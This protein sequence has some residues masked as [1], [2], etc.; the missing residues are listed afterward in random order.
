MTRWALVLAWALAGL[1]AGGC[2]AQPP[3]DPDTKAR[4]DSAVAAAEAW[5]QGID[6]GE[7]D[8]GWEQ[9]AAYLRTAV[10]KEQWNQSL[11]AAR[12]PLGEV[13]TRT[14][15]SAEF[16]RSLPGAPDGEYVVVQFKTQFGKKKQAVETV[17]P[18]R[19]ADG[20]WRVSGYYIR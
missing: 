4:V 2:G 16:H 17:T 20:T 3:A 14:L 5:L 19:E 12:L 18:M 1:S 15:H 10:T 9:S 11:R 13:V 6:R 8:T 7:Y